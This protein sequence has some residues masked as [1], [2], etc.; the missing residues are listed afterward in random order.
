[1]EVGATQDNVTPGDTAEQVI[2]D[3]DDGVVTGVAVAVELQELLPSAFC[4]DTRKEYS[5]P[6]ANPVTEA[7]VAVP[8]GRGNTTQVVPPSLEN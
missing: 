8:A 1:M 7:V 6:F 5:K 4:A 2:D 3:G